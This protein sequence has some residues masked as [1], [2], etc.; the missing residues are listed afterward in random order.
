M[1]PSHFAAPTRPISL[2][3]QLGGT[4]DAGGVWSGP[5]AVIAG[6]FDP[7]T[8]TA[9]V[10]TYTVNGIAPCPA[11]TATVTVAVNTPPDPGVDGT[12]TLCSTDAAVTLFAQ[13]GGTPDAGGVWSGP[14]AVVAG[15]FDPATMSAGVYTYTVNGI[16][17]CPAESATVTVA[18]NTPPDPGVDGTITLCSTDAAVT[19]FAQL[20]GTPDAGGVWSGPSAVVAGNFDPATMSA[21]V[22]TYTVNGIAPCPAESATVTVAVN[23]P[24]DPGVDGTITLCSTDAAVT[25]F[26]QLGGTP[27]AGGVWSG[28]SAVIAGNFDP[29]T[30]SAGVYTYTVNGIAPCPA[31]TATVTVAVNTPPDPGVDGAITLCSTDAAVA[32]FA[33]LG[34]TPDAGGVW[35]G[36]SAVVAGN[37]DPATMS[38]G[39]YTYTVNG[40]APCPAESATVTVAVNTPPDPGVDGTITLCSTDAVISLFAQLGGTPDAGGVWSGPSAVIAGNFDPATMTAGVYT[41]T[42]N[43]IAPCPAESATVTVAVNTPPDPGVDGT[44]TLCSTDAVISLFAQLGGTPDAGGV[45]SGPSA[46][47]AGNFDPATMTA[48][49]YTYTVN[50]IAPCP[51]ESATVTVAVNTPPDPGVDGAIT[52][53]ST[54]A[55]VALFAQLGG[56]PD[57]GGVWSGPSAVVAGNFDPATMSA[58]VYTYTVNGIAPCPA[59][60]ATVTVAVNTPPDPGTDGTITLCSTDAPVALFAQLGGTPDA[61]GVWSGPSAVIAGNF[62]PATM[63]AGVYTYTVNGIAPCPA[64]SATVT[65]AVN[66]PPDPGVDG[67]ITLCSTD[68]AVALFAQL[69]GTPDVGGVWSGPSA[70]IAGNFDP[71]TMSAGVYTYTVNGIAP[72]PAESATVTVAVNTP[73]DPGVD[74]T[75]TLCSTDAAVALFAQLGGTPDAGGVWSGPSAVVAGNFD[76]ATM[77]AG[78]YTYTVN[79]IAPCPAESATVTVAV[80]TPPDPGGWHHHACSTD[81]VALFAQLGERP[82]RVV[83]S[84]RARW[85]LATSTP[86]R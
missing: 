41:Y 83:W 26:A 74:G 31:E 4:P 30:M 19:L 18:V 85:S 42:V 3:A 66:T 58:G 28:P 54:D 80:N 51:A 69:G 50:G 17:P 67:T 7:A 68:A 63:S 70:V 21:G 10:Y 40:I 27:D 64:E 37:F 57:A 25:L 47:I 24:P 23:T 11:E 65:V 20:G 55:A 61:G 1:A 29:A 76:P 6:N 62:D 35:S 38:A 46:V 48:G 39:V 32:L 33:Q 60:T 79:G 86:R 53:C 16:A 75:I 43:G 36:P 49:V 59:E 77:T 44:I 45:W 5:S 72:C 2:F 84:G 12:I 71:A 9:G 14:S 34:G 73:P 22:Y 78:V 56:T 8:M 82:M 13:L 52:L 15:N 81:A